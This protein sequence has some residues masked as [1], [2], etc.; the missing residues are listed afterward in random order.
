VNTR[1]A[2]IT[3]IGAAV[4][5][6]LAAR[7]QQPAMPGIGFLNSASPGGFAPFVGAFRQG[8]RKL[9]TSKGRTPRS[10]IAGQ[11]ANMTDCPR[12]RPIWFAASSR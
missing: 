7:A 11:K 9:A 6:P 2:F 4:A 1:R 5:W 8:L 3:L 12:W 10:S